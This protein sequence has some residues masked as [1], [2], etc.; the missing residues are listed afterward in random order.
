M[1]QPDIL[2]YYIQDSEVIITDCQQDASGSLDIPATIKKLPVTNIAQYAFLDCSKLKSV[3]IPNSV[4]STG[5]N[6][7]RNCTGLKSIT[8]PDSVTNIRYAAFRG[9]T[10]LNDIRIPNSLT[11]IGQ[12]VFAECT[13]LKKI[14]IPANVKS[15]DLNAFWGCTSL[16]EI[17]I[18]HNVTSIDDYPFNGCSS[19]TGITVDKSNKAYTNDEFGVL[20][21]KERTELIQ[22]P[23]GSSET[24][25]TI[26]DGVQIVRTYAF[27]G[28]ENLTSITLPE[29]L[30]N[31]KYG[32]FGNIE[33]LPDV[34][35]AGTKEQWNDIHVAGSNDALL[36]ANVHFLKSSTT[37]D[38]VD[39]KTKVAIT[40]DDDAFDKSVQIKVTEISKTDTN[41]SWLITPTVNGKKVQPTKPVI[42][43]LP[44]PKGWDT[45]KLYVKHTTDNGKVEFPK[46]KIENGYVVF[47]ISE[48][49]TFEFKLDHSHSDDDNDGLCDTCEKQMTGGKHCKYCGQIHK[50]IG[51]FFTKIIHFFKGMFGKR[52]HE[53]VID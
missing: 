28:C 4:T 1:A 7:F 9:C 29:S 18:P 11:N 14:V 8:I 40:Y 35:Y 16:T 17:F 39:T 41:V 36:N 31:V 19:L 15:I 10:G 25:Y 43:K 3:N 44:I 53:G 50:G 27:M 13:G 42:V 45:N 30:T 5:E 49:S 24:S 2:T 20:L 47:E 6:S 51:G 52:L 38:F 48:F 37:T 26:P 46:F 12:E 22:W 21:N 32:A 23:L 34:Y 33:N